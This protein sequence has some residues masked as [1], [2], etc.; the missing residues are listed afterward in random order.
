MAPLTLGYALGGTDDTGR[1]AS[2][3]APAEAVSDAAPPPPPATCAVFCVADP[4][5]RESPHRVVT[6]SGIAAPGC[7]LR[8]PAASALL[9]AAS[10]DFGGDA[11]RA[12]E[13]PRGGACRDA[14]TGIGPATPAVR[15]VGGVVAAAAAATAF[16]A[17]ATA[18]RAAHA[19]WS[20]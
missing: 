2:M 10:L 15:D 20:M 13:P 16:F 9:A 8:G 7:Q 6:Q 3:D 5:R 14:G 19:A 4:A 11:A 12:T 17:A 1:G 18:T